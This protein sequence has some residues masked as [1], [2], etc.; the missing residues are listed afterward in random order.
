MIHEAMKAVAG[1]LNAMLQRQ[2]GDSR[3]RVILGNLSN[4]G[5]AGADEVDDKICLTLTQITEEKNTASM[6]TPRRAPDASLLLSTPICLNLHL[7]FAAQYSRYEVGLEMIS[8]VIAY[9]HGKPHFTLANTP[10]MNTGLDR[11]TL[12]LIKLTYAEQSYLWGMLGA[13][14]TPSALYSMRML[15]FG[16]DQIQA[17]APTIRQPTV[18]PPPAAEGAARR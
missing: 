14:Y 13:S 4:P 9:L 5:G 10:K 1:D 7:L 15:T 16:G 2:R 11:L 8:E 12:E 17:V 3:D 18:N 6:A